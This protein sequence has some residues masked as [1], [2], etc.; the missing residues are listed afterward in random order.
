MKL[1]TFA[2]LLTSL[3]FAADPPKPAP[4]PEKFPI[5]AEYMTLFNGLVQNLQAAQ[6]Q[7]QS[8]EEKLRTDI[9]KEKG[10]SVAECVVDWQAGSVSKRVVV[11]AAETPKPAAEKKP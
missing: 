8:A 2:L 1:I 4:Q 7:V 10:L 3:C 11:A 9:C 5:S 6:K